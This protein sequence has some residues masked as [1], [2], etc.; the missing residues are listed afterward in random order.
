MNRNIAL[1]H[2]A[3]GISNNGKLTHNYVI[4]C[5]WFIS[6]SVWCV[7]LGCYASQAVAILLPDAMTATVLGIMII[8]IMSQFC[9]FMQPFALIPT[10][11][12]FLH[13]L[14]I[15][16]WPMEGIVTS[17]FE[18]LDNDIALFGNCGNACAI[19]VN[20]YLD[21]KY[22]FVF[23]NYRYDVLASLGFVLFFRLLQFF[24][25]FRVSYLIQ[26]YE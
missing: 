6:K 10:V 11:W 3:Y 16:R 24:G 7:A 26:W 25:L 12:K 17:H 14:N 18:G 9:G 21:T 20:D 23:E 13:F 1:V 19:Q 4:P 15:L 8:T 5:S 2:V 22:G